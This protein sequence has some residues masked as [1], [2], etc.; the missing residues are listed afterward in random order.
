MEFSASTGIS[1]CRNYSTASVANSFFGSA[2]VHSVYSC[3]SCNFWFKFSC[4]RRNLKLKKS[5]NCCG[6]EIKE[7]KVQ[8]AV[9][10]NTVSSRTKAA[11]AERRIEA[12]ATASENQLKKQKFRR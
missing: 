8:Q 6:T 1:C 5:R 10:D 9:W 2:A 11:E 4:Y 3:F 7:E 12:A